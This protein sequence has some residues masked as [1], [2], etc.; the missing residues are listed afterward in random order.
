M[1]NG[2]YGQR[3]RR[4]AQAFDLAGITQHSGVPR[5]SGSWRRASRKLAG[6]VTGS[7][8][9]N[10]NPVASDLPKNERREGRFTLPI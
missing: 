3:P 1:R 10:P 2:D 8:Q 6:L 7:R 9:V 5:P 4:V